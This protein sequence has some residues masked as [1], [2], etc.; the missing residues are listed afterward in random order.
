MQKLLGI[1]CSINQASRCHSHLD[2]YI[3]IGNV[4]IQYVK[5]IVLSI[6]LP[7]PHRDNMV[8]SYAINILSKYKSIDILISLKESPLSY[9]K[10]QEMVGN[11]ATTQRRL[12]E[13]VSIG[14]VKRKVQQDKRRSVIYQITPLGL[15]CIEFMKKLDK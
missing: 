13:L 9:G 8:E 3:H 2:V 10:I 14:I 5:L 6:F 7:F 4:Y 15:E 11:P 1:F 12:T